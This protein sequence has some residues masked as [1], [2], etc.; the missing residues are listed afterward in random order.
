M[1]IQKGSITIFSLISLM[2]VGATLFALLEVARYQEI[3]RFAGLQTEAALESA[4]AN[5]NSCLW[6]NYHLL[7]TDSRFVGTVMQ[8]STASAAKGENNWL[9]ITP[10]KISL[11]RCMRL[12][13]GNGMVFLQSVSAYMKENIL[14]ESLK[15]LYSQYEAIKNLLEKSEMNFDNVGEAI[16]EMKST[17]AKETLSSVGTTGGGTFDVLDV[18]EKVANWQQKGILE[19]MLKDTEVVSEAGEDF[20]DGVLIR[21]LRVG[22][23]P[24]SWERDWTDRVLLQQYLLTYLSNFRTTLSRRALNYEIEYL[25]AGKT[26]DVANLKVVVGKLLAIR[27]AANFLY[28]VSD[29]QSVAKAEAMAG[30]YMGVTL[31][32]VLAQ[33]VKLGLLTAWAFVESILDVRALLAGKKIPLLKSEKNWTSQLENLSTLMDGFPMAKDS[34][35]GLGYE[36]YLGILLLFEEE[37]KLA[38]HTLNLQEASI[39]KT[40]G[41]TTFGIDTLITQAEVTFSYQYQSIFPFLDI[42]NAGEKWKKSLEAQAS[43]NYY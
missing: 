7:G 37:S 5:Y 30:V 35:W 9:Q 3:R 33:V 19:L 6:E 41:D 24:I 27:E 18:L 36:D 11:E 4:F 13:D 15:E 10:V 26:S 2:L 22:N 14:Y 12:T 16:E 31:N 25:L 29:P 28:L 23:M 39:Q 21:E 38:M 43:Y 20:S 40:Y 17:E 34:D 32:P 1:Q 8:E 42:V